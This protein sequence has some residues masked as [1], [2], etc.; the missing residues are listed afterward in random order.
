MLFEFVTMHREEI[1]RRC[2]AKV[3]MRSIP[4]P[5]PAEIEHG[6]PLFL[7]QLVSALRLGQSSS[8]EI[9]DSA[10]LHGHDLLAQGLSVSQVVH[11]Y[12]DVCQSITELAVETNAPISADDFRMLNGC[13]DV[14]IAGAVTEYGR[15]RERHSTNGA[16]TIASEHE[17]FGYLA[18][19]LRDLLHTMMIAFSVVKS[20]NVGVG[21]STSRIIDRALLRAR[22]LVSRSLAEVRLTEGS[23]HLE[24]FPIAEF[25]EEIVET[26]TLEANAKGITLRV[27]R[28]GEGAALKADRDLLAT[29]VMNILQNALK[30]TRPATTV[31]L[32]VGATP[33]RVL[34]EIEDECGGLPS[35]DV[36]A[37]FQPFKQQHVNRTGLG[38]GLAFSRKAVEAIGGRVTARSLPQA[39]CV[40]TVDLPKLRVSSAVLRGPVQA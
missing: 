16:R 5:T 18:H 24:E 28:G 35:G 27:Q 38:L 25:I 3:A 7:D 6:V 26:A 10:I 21:G 22:D 29:A 31:T 17:H 11:D 33:D 37:P 9:T 8:D 36:H 19:E 40:F 2:R 1:I 39:G 4:A 15:Q 30:F 23:Q 20:G 32:R 34:I 13:L 14:A 12:G